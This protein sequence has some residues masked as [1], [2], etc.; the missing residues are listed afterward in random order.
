[1]TELTEK[2]LLELLAERA[3][4]PSAGYADHLLR[5]ARRAR[6]RRRALAGV[7]G[8]AAAVV[9][10]IASL[11]PAG[12]GSAPAEPVVT[13]AT[14]VPVP[15]DR[16]LAYAA[17]IRAVAG[18]GRGGT[19]SPVKVLYVMDRLCRDPAAAPP[20]MRCEG[21]PLGERLRSDL[22]LVLKPYAPVIFI[23]DGRTVTVTGDIKAGVVDDGVVITLGSARFDATTA[24]VPLSMRRGPL[25][26]R[27]MTYRLTRRGGRWEVS[28]TSGPAWIS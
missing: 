3:P 8:A 5:R 13:P 25:D 6:S 15:S 16:A 1:M 20:P 12:P 10:L 24:V 22:A 19:G 7:A 23:A 9:C 27:G 21:S 17:A 11:A 4:A 28:G 2:E 26:G 18:E 14:S